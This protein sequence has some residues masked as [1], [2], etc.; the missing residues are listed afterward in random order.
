MA[1]LTAVNGEG[2]VG[3][4]STFE[5]GYKTSISQARSQ[6]GLRSAQRRGPLL[7]Q[8]K[9]QVENTRLN[10]DKYYSVMEQIMLLEYGAN[11]LEFSLEKQIG[12]GFSLTSERGLWDTSNPVGFRFN[13]EDDVNK[14]T[15]NPILAADELFLACKFLN[16]KGQSVTFEGAYSG[17]YV[18]SL[19]PFSPTVPPNTSDG[20][21]KTGAG[22]LI[23]K[24]F[25]YV[26]FDN[27]TKVYQLTEDAYSDRSGPISENVTTVSGVLS[28]AY[29]GDVTFKLNSPLVNSPDVR[30]EFG[31][32]TIGV[33][34]GRACKFNMMLASI[35]TI[36]YLPGNIVEFGD[37]QF[38]EVIE[39]T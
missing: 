23:G 15:G 16:Q 22:R 25:D 20:R 24:T 21:D 4:A 30:S 29:S 7:Y 1:R 12:N 11:T 10:S 39:D 18:S 33:R 38:E 8:L 17:S 34:F 2:I 27:S 32:T 31:D 14:L 37:F 35:P 36:T 5:L 6:S 26:Q 13:N 28:N 9:V 3:N 19:S